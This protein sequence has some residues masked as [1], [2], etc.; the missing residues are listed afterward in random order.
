MS[1]HLSWCFKSTWGLNGPFWPPACVRDSTALKLK[2]KPVPSSSDANPLK[3]QCSWVIIGKVLIFQ[4]YSSISVNVSTYHTHKAWGALLT[5]ISFILNFVSRP[6]ELIWCIL[7]KQCLHVLSVL[8]EIFERNKIQSTYHEIHEIRC[9]V[10]KI[11]Y[12]SFIQRV[13]N[14]VVSHLQ[15]DFNIA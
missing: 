12:T 10:T 4:C 2:G 9:Y 5:V 7:T 1:K 3:K 14:L 13:L 15:D 6:I 8:F 11:L